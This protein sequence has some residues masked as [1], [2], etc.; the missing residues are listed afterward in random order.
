MFH[1]AC[2][3]KTVLV[4]LYVI[5]RSALTGFNFVEI[6]GLLLENSRQVDQVLFALKIDAVKHMH[7]FCFLLY[8][9]PE[10][11]LHCH[12]NKIMSAVTSS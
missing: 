5:I 6:S 2:Q 3:T 4:H 7:S 9:L 11:V 1:L 10:H 8:S 12:H